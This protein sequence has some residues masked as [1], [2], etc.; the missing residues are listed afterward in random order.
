VASPHFP[1]PRSAG[2]PGPGVRNKANLPYPDGKGRGPAGPNVLPPLSRILRNKANS[3]RERAR[4]SVLWKKGY[5]E[6]GPP[7]ASAK[8]SQFPDGQEGARAGKAGDG[9][10]GDQ[11]CETKPISGRAAMG[12]G[13]QACPCHRWDLSCETKPISG[14]VS[15]LKC[16][17]KSA[18]RR[19]FPL[20]TPHFK[21]DT[22]RF[23]PI[24]RNKANLPQ[25]EVQGKYL[26][27]KE[28]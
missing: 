18:K 10:S 28:V 21:L 23:G 19:V 9:P 20:R 7:E 15:S 14:E 24:V 27:G 5:D 11:L 3:G 26:V 2:S 12:Q 1:P 25:S 17:A 4:A 22:V 6:L 13:R 16:Q 8:Q